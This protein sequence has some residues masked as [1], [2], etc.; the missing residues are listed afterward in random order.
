M[1]GTLGWVEGCAFVSY[2]SRVSERSE[3][4]RV[5]EDVLRGCPSDGAWGGRGSRPV[6]VTTVSVVHRYSQ[7][8]SSRGSP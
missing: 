3:R 4:A 8:H 5:L 6:R 1:S 7:G 2:P